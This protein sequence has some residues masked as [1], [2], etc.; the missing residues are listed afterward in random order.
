MRSLQCAMSS[1]GVTSEPGLTLTNALTVSPRFS[2]GT[3]TTADSRTAGCSARTSSTSRGQTLYP[4]ALIMSFL[5]STLNTGRLDLV[6]LN[7]GITTGET[8]IDH[9]TPNRYRMVMGVNVD[10][11]V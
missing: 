5:R 2:S 7:A 10:G 8:P 1:S 6:V 3:P 9:L 11:I 4:E